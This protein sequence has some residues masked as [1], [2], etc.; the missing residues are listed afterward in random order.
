MTEHPTFYDTIVG[1]P[2]WK[3]WRELNNETHNFDVAESEECGLLSHEHFAAFLEWQRERARC[4]MN[5]LYELGKRDGLNER[6]QKSID[7]LK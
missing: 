2:E 4:S 5:I 7:I 3:E 1:S 6:L